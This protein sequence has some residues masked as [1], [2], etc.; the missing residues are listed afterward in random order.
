M[1]HAMSLHPPTPINISDLAR[2]DHTRLRRRMLYSCY[3]SDLDVL[4]RQALGNVRADAWKPIDLTANPYLSLWQQVAVLYADAPDVRVRPGDEGVLSAVD[5]AAL[6]PLMQRVQRDTLGLREMLLRV[7]VDAEGV[8]VVR[9]VYPD[10]VEAWARQGHPSQLA[11]IREAVQDATHGWLWHDLDITDPAAP[12]YVVVTPAGV[13]LTAAVLGADYSGAAYPYRRADGAPILPYVLY[14]AAETGYLFDPF[15]M[16]EIVSG[17]LLLGLYLTYFGHILRNAAWAQRYAIGAEPAGAEIPE[18]DHSSS[19][20]EVVSD[21]ATLLILRAD[22]NMSGQPTVGQWTSP[23]DPEAVLRAISMYER[24]VLTLA[25]IQSPAVT[26]Q[27][28]DVRSGYS[29]AVA[30][31]SIRELQR[32]FEPQFRRGDA[33][34]L[35]LVATLLNR[36]TGTVYSEEPRDYRVAYRG[37]PQSPGEGKIQMEELNA[38]LAAGLIGPVSAYMEIHPGTLREEALHAVAAGRLEEA[39]V[40]ALVAALSGALAAPP[41]EGDLLV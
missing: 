38:R 28:S 5:D 32:T 26:R 23:A 9:A 36:A 10:L 4:L 13:D 39:D 18:G 35:A 7:E 8:A 16:R 20:R 1:N 12:C 24:R 3:E 25:G 30:R 15:S 11:R 2:V 31:E 6:W 37:L 17:S 40:A 14:H 21:P 27:D 29:L 33:Q 22:P 41:I 34:T 19:R